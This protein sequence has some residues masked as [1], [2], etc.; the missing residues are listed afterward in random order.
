MGPTLR[1]LLHRRRGVPLGNKQRAHNA[2][3]ST[4]QKSDKF[5]FQADNASKNDEWLSFG[6]Q[7]L[8]A[9]KSSYKI[10]M[11]TLSGSTAEFT[12][13]ELCYNRIEFR[14]PQSECIKQHSSQVNCSKVLAPITKPPP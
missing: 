3:I 1:A 11:T 13:P 8:Q 12:I 7:F 14:P 5:V 4:S 10:L 2:F 6:E 9:K